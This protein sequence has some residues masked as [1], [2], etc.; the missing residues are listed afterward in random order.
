MD[1]TTDS[2][3]HTHHNETISNAL[4]TARA[5]IHALNQDG[6]HIIAALANGRRPLLMVDRI[7]GDLRVVVKR[8]H[9]NGRGGTTVVRAA[10]AYGCQLEAMADEYPDGQQVPARAYEQRE[11]VLEQAHA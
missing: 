4:L 6:V 8:Q 7:P 11:G 9:P 1:K 10:E 5:A 2:T 3:R